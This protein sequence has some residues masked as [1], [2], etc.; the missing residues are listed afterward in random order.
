MKKKTNGFMFNTQQMEE[1]EGKFRKV[2]RSEKELKKSFEDGM[3]ERLLH[4]NKTYTYARPDYSKKARTLTEMVTFWNAG[5]KDNKVSLC[6]FVEEALSDYSAKEIRKA[7]R[8]YMYM[9]FSSYNRYKHYNSWTFL[10]P[11]WLLE[12]NGFD[13]CLDI[14][15]E[16]LRQDA[17]FQYSMFWKDEEC[18][19]IIL[20]QHGAEHVEELIRFMYEDG[21]T[22]YA[23]SIV[24]RSL[25]HIYSLVT[26]KQMYIKSEIIKYLTS[27]YKQAEE[28]SFDQTVF[29]GYCYNLAQAHIKEAMPLI[30]KFLSTYKLP[31]N[32]NLLGMDEIKEMMDSPIPLIF[33][34]DSL[35]EYMMDLLDEPGVN[36]Y[37]DMPYGDFWDDDEMDDTMDDI[38]NYYINREIVKRIGCISDDELDELLSDESGN[39]KQNIADNVFDDLFNFDESRYDDVHDPLRELYGF[40]KY[41]DYFNEDYPENTYC[42][43]VSLDNS[44]EKV[45]RYVKVVTSAYLSTVYDFLLKAFARKDFPEM[46]SF[47]RPKMRCSSEEYNELGWKGK[48]FNPEEITIGKLL[49]KRGATAKLYIL[50]PDGKDGY[51]KWEHTI[52]LEKKIVGIEEY[53]EIVQSEGVYPLESH[54]TMDDYKMGLKKGELS[55]LPMAIDSS[56]LY[57]W[58]DY[59]WDLE[60]CDIK[61]GFN[62]EDDDFDDDDF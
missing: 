26:E 25:M 41:E 3:Y 52:K 15:L 42:L 12:R 45:I 39:L 28:D 37:E 58:N 50:T 47:E 17:F 54:K 53:F 29:Y 46:Y 34:Y 61:D 5:D 56:D 14:V 33:D 1:Q 21:V 51:Y 2:Y 44:P 23:K 38:L 8:G 36:D 4:L 22:G 6:G 19:N 32:R 18:L 62:F 24:F 9:L 7:V 48:S 55:Q 60:L 49:T 40:D 13:D 11:M 30:S 20:Y 10:G 59:L 35:H 57:I 16:A 43:T 31:K 27:Y